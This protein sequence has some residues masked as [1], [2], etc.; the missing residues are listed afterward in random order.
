MNECITWKKK[1]E[2][3]TKINI[4]PASNGNERWTVNQVPARIT[5]RAGASLDKISKN[6]IF[7]KFSKFRQKMSTFEMFGLDRTFPWHYHFPFSLALSESPKKHDLKQSWHSLEHLSIIFFFKTIFSW[8]RA[9]VRGSTLVQFDSVLVWQRAVNRQPDFRDN[10][11]WS[12]LHVCKMHF[13]QLWKSWNFK[14]SRF[15]NRLF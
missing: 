1:L 15:W 5:R 2:N 10:N 4:F 8:S 12:K 13:F 3:Y 9:P 6:S 11:A 7:S 14:N